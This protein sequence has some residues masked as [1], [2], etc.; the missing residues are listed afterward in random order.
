MPL[1]MTQFSYTPEAW[2]ALVKN[3]EDRSIPVKALL[4]KFGGKLIGLYYTF[5]E[6]DGLII[7]EGPDNNA[8]MSS[9]LVSLSAGHVRALKTSPIFSS[10]EALQNMKNAGITT[11]KPPRG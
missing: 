7:S 3:P 1:Y 6:Y 8:S 11:L 2:A 9:L 5:G 4:E 10:T